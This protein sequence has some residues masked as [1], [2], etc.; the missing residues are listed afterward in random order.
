MQ[1]IIEIDA[2]INTCGEIHAKLSGSYRPGPV[3]LVVFLEADDHEPVSF[4]EKPGPEDF[5][6]IWSDFADQD[7]Q[8]FLDDLGDRRREAF[9]GRRH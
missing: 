3:H 7:F 9:A 4:S 8:D 1:Q 2:E 6:G 5:A